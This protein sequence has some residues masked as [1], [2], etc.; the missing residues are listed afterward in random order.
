MPNLH[1]YVYPL[2]VIALFFVVLAVVVALPPVQLKLNSVIDQNRSL[3]SVGSSSFTVG[4]AVL[5]FSLLAASVDVAALI[6]ILQR[7]R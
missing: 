3:V 6:F 1:K 5:I 4:D 2:T 7:D